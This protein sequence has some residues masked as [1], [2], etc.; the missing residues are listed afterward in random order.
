ME[1]FLRIL[2]Y[3]WGASYATLLGVFLVFGFVI[4][5]RNQ[6]LGSQRRI[7][8]S[9]ASSESIRRDYRQSVRSLFWIA[10]F[11]A[12]GLTFQQVG[13]TWRPYQV[14]FTTAIIGF[15]CSLLL[16]DTWFYWGHR[17]M[18]RRGFY[19]R[20]H[21][22]QGKSRSLKRRA[23]VRTNQKPLNRLGRALSDEGLDSAYFPSN[24]SRADLHG[25]GQ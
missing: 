24:R 5:W 11:L 13:L 3:F 12:G 18:H 6:R 22:G 10:G 23:K 21:R 16:F 25:L 1:A 2:F 20:I 15:V 8:K 14:T 7:Q 19:G 17:L 9:P 4:E